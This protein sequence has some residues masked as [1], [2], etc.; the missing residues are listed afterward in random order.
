MKLKVSNDPFFLESPFDNYM[1]GVTGKLTSR[2][3]LTVYENILPIAMCGVYIGY[4]FDGWDYVGQKEIE[5]C[6]RCVREV[7]R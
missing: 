2:N 4:V 7:K 6:D 3:H 5:V 1:K